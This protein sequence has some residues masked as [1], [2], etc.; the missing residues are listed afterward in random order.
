MF[1][2]SKTYQTQIKTLTK[3]IQGIIFVKKQQILAFYKLEPENDWSLN[4]MHVF[5]FNR[6]ASMCSQRTRR[7]S[8]HVQ[9]YK[10]KHLHQRALHVGQS[11]LNTWVINSCGM[12]YALDVIGE[13]PVW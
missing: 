13:V 12:Q 2:V 1:W 10:N 8:Q 4:K 11:G 3:D 6:C 7:R 5:T 9:S